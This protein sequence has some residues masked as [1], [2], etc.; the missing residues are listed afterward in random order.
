MSKNILKFPVGTRFS[1]GKIIPVFIPFA[2][3][4]FKCLYCAQ[5]VQSG[6]KNQSITKSLALL[7]TEIEYF[8]D[9][10]NDESIKSLEIAFYGGTFTALPSV[11]LE[12][13]LKEFGE[14]KNKL[15]KLGIEVYGRCSTRPDCLGFTNNSFKKSDLNLLYI[16][17]ENGIDL[18]ELGIQTFDNLGLKALGR[19]YHADL[20]KEA[21]AY[22]N[23]SGLLLGIQLMPGSPSFRSEENIFP[24]LDLSYNNVSGE[25][26]Q[27]EQKIK[28][29]FQVQSAQTF[30]QDVEIALGFQPVSL[31]YY[32]FLVLE[33]TAFA[34]LWK[35][36][37][38]GIWDINTCVN[39][40]G[41]ALFMAW[42]KD[43]SVIRLS[44]APEDGFEGAV[45]AGVRHQG[46]GGL[47]KA[48]A[49]LY[50]IYHYAKQIDLQNYY[51]YLPKN[52]QGFL[53]GDKNYLKGEWDK[54]FGLNKIIFTQE[55]YISFEQKNS[56]KISQFAYLKKI[57]N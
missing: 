36:N 15:F 10:R 20:A 11:D 32:P 33:N 6:A 9:N 53:F 19:G 44:L 52:F 17:K 43:V 42:Q 30:L 49:L 47:I 57:D 45:L 23:D 37:L 25:I 46:L 16:L 1:R 29:K 3:C 13:C 41:Y 39:A 27:T 4:P 26:I 28:S 55:E 54:I 8:C 51:L 50:G 21:C 35:N 48:R 34:K 2:G 24:S 38:L 31:R 40:L 18:L 12:L 22:V 14:I 56:K 7:R 5:D